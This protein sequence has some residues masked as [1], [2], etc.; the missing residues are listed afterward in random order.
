MLERFAFVEVPEPRPSASS[1][2]PAAPRSAA[3]RCASSSPAPDAAPAVRPARQRPCA[4]VRFASALRRA[5]ATS[6]V[7]GVLEGTC[8]ARIRGTPTTGGHPLRPQ[9]SRCVAVRRRPCVVSLVALFVSLGGV[10]YAAT[11]LP[12]NSVGT[13]QLKNG[14]VSYRRSSPTRSARSGS[15]TAASSTASSPTALSP[16]RTSSPA[17]SAQCA[18]TSTSCRRASAARAAPAARSARSTTRARSRATD[19]ARRVRHDQQHGDGDRH[20]GGGQHRR[21]SRRARRTWRSPTRRRR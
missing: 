1:S 13:A 4:S 12:D 19:A 14:A 7:R 3:T 9:I 21:R 17:R 18:P 20:R 5:A 11:Q 6:G 8:K 10:G 16:T 15:P 2:R